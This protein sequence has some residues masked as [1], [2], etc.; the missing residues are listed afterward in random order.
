MSFLSADPASTIYERRRA[1]KVIE[2]CKE[3][4]FDLILDVHSGP[5]DNIYCGISTRTSHQA[6]RAGQLLGYDNFVVGKDG[7]P[8][9]FDN[10]LV[11]EVPGNGYE[12]GYPDPT[13]EWSRR[14]TELLS[15]DDLDHLDEDFVR[16]NS[17][18]SKVWAYRNALLLPD[19]TDGEELLASSIADGPFMPIRREEA[20]IL[21]LE[22]DPCKRES[23]IYALNVGSAFLGSGLLGEYVQYVGDPDSDWRA[24][25]GRVMVDEPN[26]ALLNT[27]EPVL[28]P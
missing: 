25:A 18:E 12:E 19:G 6:I 11:V 14:F 26:W 24:R 15:Y 2:W 3:G 7:L 8:S 9:V 13:V 17:A 27:A 28:T 21:G 1:A 5:Y 23:S 10:A 4:R 22:A 20:G 16:S